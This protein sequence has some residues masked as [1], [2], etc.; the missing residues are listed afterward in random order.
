[1]TYR[2][3]I[4]GL[5]A[6]AVLS[7]MVFHFFPSVL[8]GGFLGVDIFFVISGFL[9]TGIL[10]DQRKAGSFTYRGFYERRI[11][12]L[13][14]ALIATLLLCSL[15]ALFLFDKR[16]MMD[17]GG[18]LLTAMFGVSNFY[19]YFEADYFGVQAAARPLLHTWT[20]SV[21][22]QFYL[23]WPLLLYGLVK[24]PLI[25]R[26]LLVIFLIALS[27]AIGEYQ[28]RGDGSAAFYLLPARVAELAMGGL[29]AILIREYAIAE[30]AENNR[31]V[32]LGLHLLSLAF[33]VFAFFI[34]DGDNF[35]GL[36][37]LPPAI[38]TGVLLL[39]PVKG[40]VSRI[41]N[42]PAARWIGLI[43]YS[44]Y[45]IHWPLLVFY[46]SY[47][48][49]GITNIEG[50][51]LIFVTLALASLFYIF[52]EQPFR[53][54][55]GE[56][57]KISNKAVGFL[58]ILA[59][60]LISFFAV[61]A[62][63]GQGWTLA[64]STQKNV[65]FQK[66]EATRNAA[67]EQRLELVDAKNCH[68]FSHEMDTDFS[69]CL[70]LDPV[71]DN[72]LV[73][74]SSFAA[75]DMIMMKAAYP[76][77]NIQHITVQGCL[78][79][80]QQYSKEYCRPVHEFVSENYDSINQFDLVV[81]SHNWLTS[82][83]PKQ[84]QPFLDNLS[85]PIA[86]LG[87]RGKLNTD[88]LKIIN[89]LGPDADLMVDERYIDQDEL[90]MRDVLRQL[91]QKQGLYYVDMYDILRTD[92]RLPL[93]VTE[94]ELLFHDYGHYTPAGANYVGQKF[95]AQYPQVMDLLRASPAKPE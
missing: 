18:S 52:I 8:P 64:L 6:L 33:L 45:L 15:A 59:A 80:R 11:R 14:P 35:P 81:I 53:N 67:F 65:T 55:H 17:F 40:P 82:F 26:V 2:H 31:S 77:A 37:A 74:G 29:V 69:H 41:L 95:K 23:L 60:G 58:A 24:L 88:S 47:Q 28:L 94:T 21:E 49:R 51:G 46:E 86:L 62:W 7:V 56:A 72:I 25:G 34:Y 63:A 87:P 92:D 10:Y 76:E 12:R 9:I 4:D 79:T 39:F 16:E 38:A 75:G 27:T 48:L 61:N 57:K 54:K 70:S 3:D 50:I 36:L 42:N 30:K 93:L 19:F 83:K 66:L 73:Y 1:M 22:E 85:A 84:L 20:L 32:I 43:S 91:S 78:V 89:S 5:R 13:L 44:A 68:Q 71:K 90:I